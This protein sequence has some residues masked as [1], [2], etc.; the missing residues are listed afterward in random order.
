MVAPTIC[1]CDPK[2]G[3]IRS[4]IAITRAIVARKEPTLTTS[5]TYHNTS[6]FYHGILGLKYSPPGHRQYKLSIIGVTCYSC[7]TVVS[8]DDYRSLFVCYI[9]DTFLC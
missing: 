2:Y 7:Q 8:T 4:N 6:I 9:D 5:A 3:P 1:A